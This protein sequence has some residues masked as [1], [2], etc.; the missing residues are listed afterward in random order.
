MPVSIMRNLLGFL[1]AAALVPGPARAAENE[2]VPYWAALRN[3]QT[4]MRVGPGRDYRINWT[5]VRAGFPIKVLREMEGWVLVEDPDGAR[6]WMLTQFVARKLH[7]ALVH[8]Q[9]TEIR[10]NADGTGPIRWRAEPGVIVHL[11]AC[12]SG[13]CKVDIDGRRGFAPQSALWGAGAP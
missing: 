9:V 1:M 10:E 2:S 11:G 12:T 5:Y 4:N 3:P 13:W 6:G 7:T 8:G